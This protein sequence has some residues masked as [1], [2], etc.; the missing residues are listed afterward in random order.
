VYLAASLSRSQAQYTVRDE[1]HGFDPSTLPDPTD[2]ENVGKVNGRG[3][4][5]IRTF[6]DEVSFN[7]TG[8]EITMVK[9]RTSD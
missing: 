6:M 2:P 3:L 1:G 9:R 8:N 7:E 4:F 5:L